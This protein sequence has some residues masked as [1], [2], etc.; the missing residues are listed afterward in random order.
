MSNQIFNKIN[1]NWQSNIKL[2]DCILNWKLLYEMQ[3][4]QRVMERPG[5]SA[6]LDRWEVLFS[7][8]SEI[9]KIANR[10]QAIALSWIIIRQIEKARVELYKELSDT[11]NPAFATILRDRGIIDEIIDVAV[12]ETILYPRYLSYLDGQ[13]ITIGNMKMFCG[14]LY[15]FFANEVMPPLNIGAQN[16]LNLS[17]QFQEC[18]HYIIFNAKG[19]EEVFMTNA[20]KLYCELELMKQNGFRPG[21]P[22]DASNIEQTMS[23]ANFGKTIALTVIGFLLKKPFVSEA[24]SKALMKEFK[25]IKGGHP[26]A[27]SKEL[28]DLCPDFDQSTMYF[29]LDLQGLQQDQ[30]NSQQEQQGLSENVRAEESRINPP[31]TPA[32]SATAASPGNTASSGSLPQV[33]ASTNIT[34]GSPGAVG[35]S[36]TN[37]EG[38]E[39]KQTLGSPASPWELGET[40]S[41]STNTGQDVNSRR[42]ALPDES[43]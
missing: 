33:P 30:E 4:A 7:V 15:D 27:L 3:W 18:I 9:I 36:S 2:D 21:K 17:P 16:L 24:D 14:I 23:K 20:F 35:A 12:Y 34:F 28:L 10:L 5:L 11:Y 31:V 26:G 32:S 22:S 25:R 40:G 19:T 41:S 6:A 29:Q 42:D 39:S 1:A 43:V 13:G 8:P 38:Q 37:I